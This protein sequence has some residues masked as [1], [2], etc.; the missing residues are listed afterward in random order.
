MSLAETALHTPSHLEPDHNVSHPPPPPR[1]PVHLP[2]M[3]SFTAFLHA[4]STLPNGLYYVCQHQPP[5]NECMKY[6]A[7]KDSHVKP[8]LVGRNSLNLISS[9]RRGHGRKA[10]S[11]CKVFAVY[12]PAVRACFPGLTSSLGFFKSLFSSYIFPMD[13]QYHFF[14]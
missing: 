6:S 10:T 1:S 13:V 12:A 9:V 7:D 4:S 8:Q 2:E 14:P 5:S 3:N 11:V